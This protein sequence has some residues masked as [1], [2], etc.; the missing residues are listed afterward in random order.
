M[1]MFESDECEDGHQQKRDDAIKEKS[2]SLIFLSID[3][4]QERPV[5]KPRECKGEE[6]LIAESCEFIDVADIALE[7][8]ISG[9]YKECCSK[10]CI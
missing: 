8:A 4:E 2:L 9:H 1:R 3:D 10:K 6:H 7:C 5:C